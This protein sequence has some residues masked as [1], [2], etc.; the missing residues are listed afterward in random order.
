MTIDSYLWWK[1][2]VVTK[3]WNFGFAARCVDH[4]REG[5]ATK[6]YHIGRVCLISSEIHIKWPFIY[7]PAVRKERFGAMVIH[8]P[9]SSRWKAVRSSE[10]LFQVS[11]PCVTVWLVWLWVKFG[12]FFVQCDH[13]YMWPTAYVIT[14]IW[15]IYFLHI[16]YF[17]IWVNLHLGTW[18]T[19]II[20]FFQCNMMYRSDP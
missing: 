15:I 14:Q 6:S 8:I 19:S 2:I 1:K 4:R 17:S 10:L 13:Q 11:R 20:F 3:D 18:D 9:W 16:N 5:A 12:Y 7:Y